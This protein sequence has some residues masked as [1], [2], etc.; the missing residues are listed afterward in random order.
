[1]WDAAQQLPVERA[2]SA[3]DAAFLKAAQL[4]QQRYLVEPAT[5]DYRVM[6][7]VTALELAKR[8][9]GYDR[10]L[11]AASTPI[12]Q[13]AAQ[14]GTD[15]LEKVLDRALDKKL[16]GAAIAAIDL[17]GDTARRRARAKLRRP[18]AA[19][20]QGLVGPASQGPIRGCASD[21]EVRS[22]EFVPGQ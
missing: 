9:E 7:L 2:W 3:A 12:V 17:L 18:A 19:V 6:Y 10:P 11:T 8:Q 16:Y 1:M 4:A 22:A 14:A 15:V 5:A 21:H 13:E 20:G